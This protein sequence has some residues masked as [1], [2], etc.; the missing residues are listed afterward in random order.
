MLFNLILLGVSFLNHARVRL[1]PRTRN[2]R[3]G[4]PFYGNANETITRLSDE[5]PAPC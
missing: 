3:I 1:S 5:F 4:N 2:E